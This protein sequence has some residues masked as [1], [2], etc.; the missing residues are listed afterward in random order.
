MAHLMSA[1]QRFSKVEAFGKCFKEVH[2]GVVDDDGDNGCEAVD[3]D[4]AMDNIVNDLVNRSV[5]GTVNQHKIKV[6]MLY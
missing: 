6:H 1:L 4:T 3:N 2:K 5:F